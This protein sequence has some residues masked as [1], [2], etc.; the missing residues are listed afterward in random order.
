MTFYIID[1]IVIVFEHT[2]APEFAK[3]PFFTKFQ[4]RI[5]QKLTPFKKCPT[6]DDLMVM[7]QY[8]L[9]ID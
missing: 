3:P 9:I 7:V 6:S 8:K 4:N 5:Q 2:D 1:D